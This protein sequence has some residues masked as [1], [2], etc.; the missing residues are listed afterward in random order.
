MV[1]VTL[2]VRN[3]P[4]V[5]AVLNLCRRQQFTALTAILLCAVPLISAAPAE[6]STSSR[7]TGFLIDLT[8]ARE[9]KD[10]EPSLG[11]EHTKKCMQMPLCDRSG[12][13]LLTDAHQLLHFDEAGNRT[14]RRLLER[15]K[16]EKRL[17]CVVWGKRSNDLVNVS[18]VELTNR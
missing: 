10:K 13:G 8:C 9:R 2:I 18:R 12:F 7:W 15:T 11:E 1:P 14:V 6:N 3:T 17:H 4:T 16:R 5:K